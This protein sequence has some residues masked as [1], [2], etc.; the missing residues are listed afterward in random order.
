MYEQHGHTDF[1][2]LL[3]EVE[4]DL[5]LFNITKRMRLA[6]VVENRE[7]VNADIA[8]N[9]WRRKYVDIAVGEVDDGRAI[10]RS[11]EL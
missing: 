1:A 3:T 10:W 2:W 11:R 6:R 4:W 5:A 7:D 8:R 9:R